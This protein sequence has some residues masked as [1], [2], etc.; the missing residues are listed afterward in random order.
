MHIYRLSYLHI[1]I[2]TDVQALA[3][4]SLPPLPTFDLFSSECGSCRYILLRVFPRYDRAG[5]GVEGLGTPRPSFTHG[6]DTGLTS[7]TLRFPVGSPLVQFVFYLSLLSTM[8]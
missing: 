5:Q 6:P 7:C 1:E 8:V 4:P 3:G 2:P